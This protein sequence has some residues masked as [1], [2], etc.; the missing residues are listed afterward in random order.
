MY[1]LAKKPKMLTIEQQIDNLKR[2]V[3][4]QHPDF[5]YQKGI[6]ISIEVN[7][8]YWVWLDCPYKTKEGKFSRKKEFDKDD[9]RLL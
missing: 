9:I 5:Q 2:R 3:Y 8:K 7:K 4:I 1:K 6:L